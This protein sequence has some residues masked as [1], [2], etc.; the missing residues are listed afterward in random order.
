MTASAYE[1][2]QP[3]G[4]RSDGAGRAG[5]SSTSD[6]FDG[7]VDAFRSWK[8]GTWTPFTIG[9]TIVAFVVAWPVGLGLLA[10]NLWGQ[11]MRHSCGHR[12]RWKSSRSRRYHRHSSSGNVAFDAYREETLRRLEEEQVAF[13]EY[14]EKLRRAKDQQEFDSFMAERQMGPQNDAPDQPPA[15]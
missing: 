4:F 10:Y 5:N 11:N 2:A 7:I 8:P 6:L 1:Q 15:A 12:N 14:L 3:N 13:A 9:I